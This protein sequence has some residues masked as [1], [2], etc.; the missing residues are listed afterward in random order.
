MD[1]R[2]K[3]Y[4]TGK[5]ALNQYKIYN[6][7]KLWRSLVKQKIEGDKLSKG[8][9]ESLVLFYKSYYPE[10]TPLFHEWYFEKCG[11]FDVNYI[12]SDLYFGYIDPYFN[13]WDHAEFV[14]NKCMYDI[15]W[16]GVKQPETV[17]FRMN[18]MWFEASRRIIKYEEAEQKLK[19][20]SEVFLKI[21]T[22]SF[23]GHGV[24]YYFMPDGEKDIYR[25]IDQIKEDIIIQR[26]VRQHPSLAQL[27]VSSVNT[28]RVMS[29]LT[30]GGVKILS[31]IVRIGQAGSRVDNASSGGLTCGITEKGVLKKY[32]YNQ[33]GNRTEEH[34]DSHIRFEN[35]KIEGVEKIDRVIQNIHCRLPHFRLISWDFSIDETGEPVLIEANINYGGVEIHQ[36]NN[37]PIFGNKT[38]EILEEVFQKKK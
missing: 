20:E 11:I 25:K 8:Q 18:G 33:K 10:I 3:I 38:K 7:E 35:L 23:G 32:A 17:V 29:F 9:K 4:N 12:P 14:G 6:R 1:I 28:I 24:Y 36:I 22:D 37:G 5:K 15:L 31:R 16:G 19:R 30:A 21:A 26:P 13:N 2:L 34:P 27:N